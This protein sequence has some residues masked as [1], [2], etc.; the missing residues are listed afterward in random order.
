MNNSDDMSF[1]GT[2]NNN[3]SAEEREKF[4]EWRSK[5]Y[6]LADSI[7]DWVRNQALINEREIPSSIN[8]LVYHLA[9]VPILL[10]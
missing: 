1:F 2:L 5:S 9:K 10:E 8:E 6:L 3:C 7:R 4:N